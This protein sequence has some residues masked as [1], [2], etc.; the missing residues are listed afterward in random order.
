M[1]NVLHCRDVGFDCEG[2]IRGETEESILQ[3][4]AEHV[5]DTHGIEALSPD[6]TEEILAKIK[7]E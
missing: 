3:Q 2:V 7:D 5:A 1:A 6:M 4:A